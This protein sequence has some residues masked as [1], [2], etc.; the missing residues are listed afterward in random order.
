M[1]SSSKQFIWFQAAILLL[2]LGFFLLDGREGQYAFLALVLVSRI[3][4]YGFSLGEQE[5]R[6]RA[7]SPKVA[8][9]VNGFAYALNNLGTLVL[10]LVGTL[11]GSAKNFM[12]MVVF[13]ASAVMLA[14]F[15]F[16]LWTKMYER[17][18]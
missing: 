7:I 18:F 1:I 15:L 12:W 5:I 14:A 6:Q 8:G 10:Y 11:L 4:L 9:K 2:A 17:K 3:G 13:S 16:Q